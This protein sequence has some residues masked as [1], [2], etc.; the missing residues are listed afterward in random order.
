ME[1][2]TSKIYGKTSTGKINRENI[3]KNLNRNE[4][5]FKTIYKEYYYLCIF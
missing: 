5:I 2:E 4:N 3:T 1:K